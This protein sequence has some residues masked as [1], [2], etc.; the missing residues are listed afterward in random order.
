VP[1]PRTICWLVAILV[2]PG[3]P[4]CCLVSFFGIVVKYIHTHTHTYWK[5]HAFYIPTC[6]I[7]AA[8]PCPPSEPD[9]VPRVPHM[10]FAA[11]VVPGMK[12]ELAREPAIAEASVMYFCQSALEW[13]RLEVDSLSALAR[14][15][16][17]WWYNL[18]TL[19]VEGGGN[20]SS[21]VAAAAMFWL[22]LA[23]AG[24]C[25]PSWLMV[26]VTSLP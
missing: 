13:A 21:S 2:A 3:H 24:H 23:K 6:G 1:V 15:S 4:A 7:W 19:S 12:T 17:S 10:G 16:P 26:G 9:G 8:H 22:T 18:F 5:A 25:A 11:T 14:I 20:V